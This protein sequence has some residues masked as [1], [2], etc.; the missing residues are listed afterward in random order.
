MRHY[1]VAE[2]I[3]ALNAALTALD[4]I[5]PADIKLVQSFKNPPAAIKLVMVGTD[6]STLVIT[7]S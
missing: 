3:P 4:T 7:M 6:R 1:I 5:K 2:A